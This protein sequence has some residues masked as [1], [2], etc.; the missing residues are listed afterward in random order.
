MPLK[1]GSSTK[2]VQGN[3]AELLASYKTK[4]H[5]GN[6]PTEGPIKARKRAWAI[7]FDL[8]DRLRKK[9]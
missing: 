7:A 3:V 9:T 8:R 6:S 2:T 4:G 1:P 5:I